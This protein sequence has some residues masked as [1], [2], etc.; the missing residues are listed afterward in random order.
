[1]RKK[2]KPRRQAMPAAREERLSRAHLLSMM[3]DIAMD[4]EHS[5]L[6]RIRATELLMHE[7]DRVPDDKRNKAK[8]LMRLLIE[9]DMDRAMAQ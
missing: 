8:E 7:Q 5:P 3:E 9:T 6:A 2:P 4:R 1:M